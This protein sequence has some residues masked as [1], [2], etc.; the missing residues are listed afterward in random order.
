MAVNYLEF[1]GKYFA[2]SAH[3]VCVA[4]RILTNVPTDIQYRRPP[5]PVRLLL[6]NAVASIPLIRAM[7]DHDIWR[8][9]AKLSIADQNIVLSIIFTPHFIKTVIC[10]KIFTSHSNYD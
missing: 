5:V 2:N 1:C 10:P 4:S 8:A 6:F 9:A 7:C 3:S